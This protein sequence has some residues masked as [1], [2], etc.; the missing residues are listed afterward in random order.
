MAPVSELIQ[1]GWIDQIKD[2]LK[3][4][5]WLLGG[6]AVPL[7]DDETPEQ[8]LSTFRSIYAQTGVPTTL[9]A[10]DAAAVLGKVDQVD[11][12]LSGAPTNVNS[13]DISMTRNVLNDIRSRLTGGAARG[14]NP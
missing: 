3:D 10:S 4:I 1:K 13:Q 11:S 9:S 14:Q 5:I 2:I 12:A 7:E 6:D 8:A